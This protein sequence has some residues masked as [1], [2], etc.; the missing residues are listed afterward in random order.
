M[1][2]TIK[3][4]KDVKSQWDSVWEDDTISRNQAKLDYPE[5]WELYDKYIKKDGKILEAGVGL[6]KWLNYFQKK[7]YDIVGID[8]SEVAIRKLKEFDNSL[9]A[10]YGDVTEI[11]FENDSFDTYLSFGTLEHLEKISDL[12]KAIDEIHRVLKRD[13]IAYITIPNLNFLNF[14]FSI[15]NKVINNNIIRKI[16]GKR[17][18]ESHFFE[19]NYTENEFLKYFDKTKFEV[20]AVVPENIPLILKRFKFLKNKNSDIHKFDTNLNSFGLKLW[21]NLL[22][23]PSD[24]FIRRQ[25]SHLLIYVIK[26]KK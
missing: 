7:D 5:Y 8:Y 14:F 4:E 22:K 25:L 1:K 9:N 6:G 17:R 19:Y 24:S 11:P 26:I 21:G 23:R 16:F 13:G 10:V 18:V 15:K 20:C 2:V 12:K 3:Y